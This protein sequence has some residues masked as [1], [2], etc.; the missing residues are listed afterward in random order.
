[1]PESHVSDLLPGYA[2][3]N[4][5]DHELIIVSRHL[6]HCQQCQDELAGFRS[7][8]DQLAFAAK[9]YEPAPDLKTR[10][11]ARVE[12]A[13]DVKRSPDPKGQVL[14]PEP[15]L[16][17]KKPFFTRKVV[18][19]LT[20]PIPQAALFGLVALVL[21]LS[22]SSLFLWSRVAGLE[23]RVP[24]DRVKIVRLVGTDQAANIQGYLVLFPG[25]SY[26][27]LVVNDAPR[28]DDHYQYQL[29]L[30]RD[31]KRTNG[32]VFSVNEQ[33]Y[34]TVMI[35]SAIPLDNYQSFGVTIE[36][37]GGSPGP[38]GKKVLGGDL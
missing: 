23:K 35:D 32:G 21:L 36:P 2:L 33:G 11:V 1:M 20:Q 16:T 6:P 22:V 31:G 14:N 29:W 24:G 7:T 5:D 26:G 15:R 9:F 3:G 17:G 25:E 38:T 18:Q 13:A 28:L 37:A 27:T 19:W 8:V 12:Q 34:G 10:V 4:L 30:I